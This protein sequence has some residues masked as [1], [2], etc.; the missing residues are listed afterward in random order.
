[1]VNFSKTCQAPFQSS[2]TVLHDHPLWVRGQPYTWSSGLVVRGSPAAVRAGGLATAS[3]AFIIT[4]DSARAAGGA[5][6][7]S[8]RWTHSPM[9]TQAKGSQVP[10]GGRGALCPAPHFQRPPTRPFRPPSGCR[11]R[12]GVRKECL[13]PTSE[14]GPAL[15]ARGRA[16]HCL[17]LWG[18]TAWG[19]T[20]SRHRPMDRREVISLLGQLRMFTWA[21]IKR[22]WIQSWEEGGQ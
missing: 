13:P 17:L 3:W 20:I 12:R 16:C 4:Q 21:L 14:M 10:R 15:P 19:G 18:F 8:P 7:S 2:C 6:I 11:R 1:M 5:F 22:L 9:D